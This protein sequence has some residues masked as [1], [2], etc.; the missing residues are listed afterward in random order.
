MR[1]AVLIEG[2]G[3]E[4]ITQNLGHQVGSV[5]QGFFGGLAHAGADFLHDRAEHEVTGQADK[6]HIDQEDPDPQRHQLR[7]GL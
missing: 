2:A 4:V 1:P 5:D 3:L 6:Q 7:S